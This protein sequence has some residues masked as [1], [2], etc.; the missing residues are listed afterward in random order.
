MSV[1]DISNVLCT[2]LQISALALLLIQLFNHI[3]LYKRKITNLLSRML[4]ASILACG[5]EIMWHVYNNTHSVEIPEVIGASTVPVFSLLA[6]IEL[7][8]YFMDRLG[9]DVF[10]KN[11]FRAL[12]CYYLP[13]LFAA[14]VSFISIAAH[15]VFTISPDG[16][17]DI[18]I[19][20]V[21]I[22]GTLFVLYLFSAFGVAFYRYIRS[23]WQDTTARQISSFLLFFFLILIAMFLVQAFYFWRFDRS[24]TTPVMAWAVGLTYLTMSV[25]TVSLVNSEAKVIAMESDLRTASKIQMQSIPS[26]D[27]SL[28]EMPGVSLR[29]FIKPAREVGGDFYDYFMLDENRLCFLIA[30]VSGKGVPAALFMMRTRDAIR[31]FSKRYEEV[32]AVFNAVNQELCENNPENMFATAWIGI[33][34]KRTNQLHYTNA[35]HDFPFLVR[36]AGGCRVLRNTH[37]M[38]LGG[39]EESKYRSSGLQLQEGDSL[40]LYTDG[41]IEAQDK[42]QQQYGMERARAAFLKNSNEPGEV[43]LERMIQDVN[44]FAGGEAQYDDITMMIL[45]IGE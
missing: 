24:F 39:E 15:I 13:F 5:A 45:K 37:G 8:R 14:A 32:S 28:T 30:D 23:K 40:L 25:N 7:H 9:M 21:I 1:R 35:G 36:N 26:P 43:I 12:I 27:P 17:F 3:V 33:L 6:I 16:D 42:R 31:N 41:L 38:F 20:Y 22:Y 4:I 11:R 34:D 29:A 19:W 44:D 2:E 18:T 10:S